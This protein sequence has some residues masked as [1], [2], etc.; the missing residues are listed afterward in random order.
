MLDY[1]SDLVTERYRKLLAGQLG[2]LLSRSTSLALNPSQKIPARPS[3][4]NVH[5]DDKALHLK[6]QLLPQIVDDAMSGY[7]TTL[8]T[9]AIF[10]MI[11]EVR[12]FFFSPYNLIGTLHD[13]EAE[14]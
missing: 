9:G 5:P 3:M 2:N 6:M 7:K 11:A 8:A 10:D 13:L 4:D 14:N 12:V 1:S